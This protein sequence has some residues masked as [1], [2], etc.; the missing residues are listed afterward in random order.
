MQQNTE[1][2]KFGASPILGVGLFVLLLS[3]PPLM[4][5]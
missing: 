4:L 2:T 5:F 1:G 3:L